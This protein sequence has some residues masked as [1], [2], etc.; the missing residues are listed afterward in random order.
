MFAVILT[1]FLFAQFRLLPEA[2]G[3]IMMRF[4]MWVAI[5]ALLFSI[6]AE[7]KLSSL[8]APDFYASF[9]GSLV[10]LAAL[11]FAFL[12]ILQKMPVGEATMSAFMSVGSNT[13]FVALPVL[14]GVFG[15]K[16][17]L[18]TAIATVILI[19]LIV[20]TTMILE[21]SSTD[22]STTSIVSQAGRTLLNPL[23]LSSLLGI[24]YAA[25]GFS[26]ARSGKTI[27]Q[28]SRLGRDALCAVRNR[29]VGQAR[30]H[31]H[32]CRCDFCHFSDQTDCLS[33]TGFRFRTTV[34]T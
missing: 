6:I 18:P 2:T 21:K 31:P 34:E 26:A 1:G 33:G 15:E 19:V 13:A 25:T 8:L 12:R 4:A 10:V 3:D 9:G 23:V 27:P 16:A 5:P 17:V 20:I 28:S 32:R 22:D 11:V 14:H 24:A 7:E 30:R 29:L